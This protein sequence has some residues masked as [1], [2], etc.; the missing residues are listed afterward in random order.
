V[1]IEPAQVDRLRA[2]A[3]RAPDVQKPML[4]ADGGAD[5]RREQQRRPLR[6]AL[7]RRAIQGGYSI[8]CVATFLCRPIDGVMKRK[9][10]LGVRW[11]GARR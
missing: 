2:A 8:D 9:A 6:L 1:P 3:A 7:V 10:E 5:R 4:R 11:D